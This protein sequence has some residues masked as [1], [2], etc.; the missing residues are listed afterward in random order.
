MFAKALVLLSTL[1]PMISVASMDTKQVPSQ[2]KDAIQYPIGKV[3]KNMYINGWSNQMV[4][5]NPEDFDGETAEYGY[6]TEALDLANLNIFNFNGNKAIRLSR[7]ES[8]SYGLPNKIENYTEKSALYI[9]PKTYRYMG[10]SE[11]EEYV[12][13]S[14][15]IL[16][17]IV[18]TIYPIPKYATV[19]DKGLSNKGFKGFL[20][21]GKTRGD[22]LSTF[23]ENW[24]LSGLSGDTA[25]LCMIIEYVGSALSYKT[26]LNECYIINPH[27]DILG[28]DDTMVFKSESFESPKYFA[29]P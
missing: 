19:G 8:G 16:A 26:N 27:G 10:A 13:G 28:R 21:E 20:N 15:F 23:T 5:Q 9:H 6:I 18:T 12:D 11:H 1:L 2:T 14:L 17:D 22:K 24:H 7:T 3:F 4:L 29:T 25:K